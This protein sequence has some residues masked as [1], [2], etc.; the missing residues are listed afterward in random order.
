MASQYMF[1]KHCIFKAHTAVRFNSTDC[2]SRILAKSIYDYYR[3]DSYYNYP[4]HIEITIYK[5]DIFFTCPT[6]KNV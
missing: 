2:L 5:S 6:L 3:N 1:N 4:N